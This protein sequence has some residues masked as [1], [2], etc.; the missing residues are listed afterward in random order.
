M[1]AYPITKPPRSNEVPPQEAESAQS[2]APRDVAYRRHL[3]V[4]LVL[5]VVVG[6]AYLFFGRS[7]DVPAENALL[8]IVIIILSIAPSVFYLRKKDPEPMPVLPLVGLFYMI[9]FALPVFSVDRAIFVM[10]RPDIVTPA[11][12]FAV[13]GGI[14]LFYLAYAAAKNLLFRRVRSLRLP[15][16]FREGWLA[17][18][19]WLL[20]IPHLLMLWMPELRDLPSVQ[21]ILD[22]A[23]YIAF[24]MF[25]LMWVHKRLPLVQT[26]VLAAICLPIELLGRFATGALLQIVLFAVF[27]LIVYWYHARRVP[28]GLIA[29]MC[30]F[31]V[32]LQPVKDAFRRYTWTNGRF[33]SLNIVGKAKLFGEMTWN[34]YT[35]PH[36][37]QSVLDATAGRVAHIRLLAFVMQQSPSPVPY[38]KGETYKSLL[39]KFIPRFMWPGKPTETLAH[40]FGHRYSILNPDDRGTAM[41]LPWLVELWV[42]F[43]LTGLIIGMLIYG[44]L[45]GYLVRKL[46]QRDMTLL[47]FVVGATVL[48]PLCVNQESHFSVVAGNTLL[49]YVCL[50]AYFHVGYLL[51]PRKADTLLGMAPGRATG[52]R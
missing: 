44:A 32:L 27:A 11:S 31:F 24:G 28:W 4:A 29:V 41:N 7:T 5:A 17:F 21:S 18:L 37:H 25:F 47:E 33:A 51:Q 8:A 50:S 19:L 26:I 46:N 3:S 14:L 22:P 10:L 13:I 30:L 6:C 1:A 43:G 9:A 12:L 40:D 15:T 38:W 48:F 49:L 52:G 36:P 16:D 45:F 39:T 35:Q 42:N 2:S 23:G 34:F 20:L